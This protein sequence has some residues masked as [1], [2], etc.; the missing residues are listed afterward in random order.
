M[1]DTFHSYMCVNGCVHNQ[2]DRD[3][4]LHVT[5][6]KESCSFIP[7]LWSFVLICERMW[8]L[9]ASSKVAFHFDSVSF[10]Q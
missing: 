8:N 4:V 3:N 10:N 5:K 9:M 6:N 7:Y 1:N 2:E